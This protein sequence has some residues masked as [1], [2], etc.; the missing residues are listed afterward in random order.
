MSRVNTHPCKP[1]LLSL[2]YRNASS[3][4]ATRT[5]GTTGPNG[6]SQHR[7]MSSVTS[8]TSAGHTRFW[9]RRHSVRIVA[10]FATASST[11]PWM[12]SADLADITAVICASSSGAPTVNRRT[13]SS[14]FATKSSA[15]SLKATTIFTAVHRCPL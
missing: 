3:S 6:S 8:S 11:R 12:K 14:T 4:V 15:I 7:R 13:F 5:I 1:Y 9:S 2:T 10:P